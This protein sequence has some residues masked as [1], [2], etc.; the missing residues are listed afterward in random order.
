MAEMETP[1]ELDL[2]ELDVM[3]VELPG[4]EGLLDAVAMGL[5]NTEIGASGTPSGKSYLI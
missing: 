1:R 2:G 5:G 3:S 4:A